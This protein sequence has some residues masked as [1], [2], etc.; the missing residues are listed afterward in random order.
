VDHQLS[1]EPDECL[2]LVK[3]FVNDPPFV[4]FYRAGIKSLNVFSTAKFK[5][6]FADIK[7]VNRIEVVKTI[8]RDNPKDWPF[9]PPAPLFY[10]VVRNDTTDVLYG[11]IDGFR[12]LGVPYMP[13]IVPPERW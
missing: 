4:N 1:V 2:S 5:M 7:D 6:P 3:Y 9:P 13:H 11:T 8:G 12:K 10:M